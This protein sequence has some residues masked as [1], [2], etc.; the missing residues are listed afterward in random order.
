MQEEWRN[1]QGFDGYYQVSNTGRVK[2]VSSYNCTKNGKLLKPYNNSGYLFVKLSVNGKTHDFSVHRLVAT[3]FIPN[4]D[5][6][7]CVDHIDCQR[8]N[9]NADNLRWVDYSENRNNPITKERQRMAIKT[10]NPMSGKIGI[11][12]CRSKAIICKETG[13]LYWGTKEAER[14]TGVCGSNI[15][16]VLIGKQ[17]TSGGYHWRYATPDEIEQAKVEVSK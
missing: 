12:H 9:N 17:K 8:S 10:N 14:N 15:W 6:K 5:N 4:P 13:V 2:R 16:K 7:P 1:I 11:F 3:T